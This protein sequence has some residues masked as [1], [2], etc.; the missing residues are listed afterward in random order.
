MRKPTPPREAKIAAFFEK[1]IAET[2]NINRS[3][4]EE[5][6]VLTQPAVRAERVSE[7][8][9]EF[10]RTDAALQQARRAS[11]AKLD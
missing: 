2:S 7:R 1:L 10:M 6:D 3:P 4:Q 9:K 8:A 11:F 5:A